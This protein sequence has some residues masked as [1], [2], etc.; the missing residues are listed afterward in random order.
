M[1]DF[2]PPRFVTVQGR[3]LAYEEVCPAA[4]EGT[5][6]L[7]CGIGAKRQGWYR[8]LPVLGERLRTI[9]VDYRDVGD[10]DPSPG[11][12]SIAD[13]AADVA[14]LMRE[15]GIE[16]ASL[17]GVSMGGFVALEL[18]LRHPELVD[19]LVLVVTSAGGALHVSTS[20]EIMRLLMPGDSPVETGD[21]A[22]RVCAAVAAPGFAER[23]P[24]AIDEFVEIARHRPMSR[25]GYLRQLE[26]CRAHD[27]AGR[28]NE[29]RAPTLVLHGDVDPLVPLENGRRLAAR[30]A[31]ARLVVYDDTGHIPEVERA[32]AFDRDVLAFLAPVRW[33]DEIDAVLA[34]DLTAALGYRTPAG[35][36]VVQAIAPIGLRDRD[37]RDVAFTTSFGFSRKLERIAGDPRVALAYHAREHGTATS[38]LYVLV[39]GRARVVASPTPAERARLR[40]HAETHLGP[41]RDGAFWRRWLREYNQ[42]RVPVHVAID[43]IVVWPDLGCAGEPRVIGAPL[44]RAAPPPQ[45]VPAKGAG[46]RVD[47]ERALR[48]LRRTSH[49]LLGY[50]GADGRPV[51]VPVTLG[52]ADAAGLALDGPLP[53]GGR[54]AGLLGHSYRRQLIGLETRQYTG[55]LADGNYAPHT[56]HGYRAPP[57]KTLLLLLNGLLAK[58]GVRAARRP[59]RR[60]RAHR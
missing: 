23:H 31:G 19:R 35:G 56:E 53:L 33:D 46:P 36:V 44:D 57:N 27:V 32:D 17:V 25:E 49:V 58:R 52:A 11:P 22:R 9:A 21:G 51:V 43:R 55:W 37:A 29:I 3:R 15:L 60:S 10:S 48:R 40:E 26:A 4:P 6:L 24:E 18:A 30:I 41:I 59:P 34:G 28:L 16:R 38:E 42:V 14:A 13:V 7:L 12:Y 47:V 39:Q 54:R 20:P 1:L 2:A 50:A 5:V 45:P 8:Q